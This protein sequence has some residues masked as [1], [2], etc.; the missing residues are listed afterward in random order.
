MQ[1]HG[2]TSS[3]PG[4]SLPGRNDKPHDADWKRASTFHIDGLSC[5]HCANHVSNALCSLPGVLSASVSFS[6]E[7]AKVCHDARLTHEREIV[8]SM[9]QRGFWLS[10]ALG[11][12]GA[13]P[14]WFDAPRL[15][16]VLALVGNLIALALWTPARTAPRLPWVELAFAV[17]LMLIAAPPL[18]AR[19]YAHAKQGIWGAEI[20]AL[21]A[22]CCSVALGVW[23]ML[24][25]G[26]A[27]PLIPNFL[28]RLGTRPDGAAVLAFEGA[29]AIL[30]FAFLG[31]H[32]HQSAMRKA[33][34]DVDRAV[35]S[36]YARVRRVIPRGDAFV[37][38]AVLF[39]GDRVRLMA[40]EV[41]LADLR[42]D[43]AARVA[44]STGCLEE[45]A[46]GQ[47]LFRGERL[48][49]AAATG[50]IEQL[51][52]MDA[53]AAAD[54]AVVQTTS[55]I[56]HNALRREGDRVE[57][58]TAFALAIASVWF[59][60]FA[61]IMHAL[62]AR[63][64][65]HPGVFLAG[66]TVLVGASSAAFTFG[67]PLARTVAVLRA[68]TAGVV[69]NDVSALEALGAINF[70]Y[71]DLS[72]DVRLHA[73]HAFRALWHRA[74][75]CRIVSG[76]DGQTVVALGHRF[77]VPATGDLGPEDK[78]RIVGTTR[79]AGGQVLYVGHDTPTARMIP[80]DV[81]IAVAPTGSAA[82]LTAPIVLREPNLQ[83]VVW[84]V[85]L[86][87]SLRSR[88][89]IL[90]ASTLV[91]DAIIIPLC[92]AGLLAPIVAAALSFGL[93]MATNFIA[94]RVCLPKR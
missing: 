12:A 48:V 32:V 94:S 17:L 27:I 50:R 53:S 4:P 22:A 7:T 8:A 3:G 34:A 62:L 29:G 23:C 38:C 58:M 82:D 93:T 72:G 68:R 60:V 39:P 90:L 56:E 63:R 18:A 11:A 79:E 92:V 66:V 33:F 20:M 75:A 44:A 64:S 54:A 61:I 30:G 49:S 42:L 80:A 74:I 5:R 21:V 1:T 24:F 81:F 52:R 19:A 26:E 73:L 88:T 83:L 15:G 35:R 70:A 57:S 25:E 51:P 14:S 87:R 41:A 86:A 89:H 71:F 37:P 59:A 46:P 16:I 13:K 40:G 28:F 91:Y 65:P 76:D 43:V 55:L 6:T 2:F 9:A 85:D 78:S 45:R 47:M 84:L 36:R 31:H 77:G 69:V 10:P 67:L